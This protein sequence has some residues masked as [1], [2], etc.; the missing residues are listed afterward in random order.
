MKKLI[1]V[2]VLVVVGKCGAL[3][4]NDGQH[5]VIDYALNEIVELGNNFWDEPTSATLTAMGQTYGWA[6]VPLNG[7]L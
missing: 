5:H 4:L 7:A 1:V 2:L 3:L 6:I